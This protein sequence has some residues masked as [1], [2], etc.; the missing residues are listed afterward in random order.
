MSNDQDQ[1]N[2]VPLREVQDKSLSELYRHSA[3]EQPSAALDARI[4]Q[5][6]HGTV[7]TDNHKPMHARPRWLPLASGLA[8]SVLVAVLVVQLLP[9]SQTTQERP[10]PSVAERTNTQEQAR[11]SEALEQHD[12]LGSAAPASTAPRQRSAQPSSLQPTRQ[13]EAKLAPEVAPPPPP[14]SPPETLQETRQL[15]SV[16]PA[17]APKK[18]AAAAAPMEQSG[19]ADALTADRL[20]EQDALTPPSREPQ[21]VGNNGNDPRNAEFRDIA[22]LWLEGRQEEAV[23]RFH[24]FRKSYPDYRAPDSERVVY[25]AL[26][27]A[28]KQQIP[29]DE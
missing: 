26:V 6:A 21:K 24:L 27:A 12:L 7:G 4:L 18:E 1:S 19:V 2:V 8:A 13:A 5:A 22:K 28:L 14:E 16:Q 15:R 20:A 9:L 17:Y 25:A 3:T 10:R 23:L 11:V 29:E